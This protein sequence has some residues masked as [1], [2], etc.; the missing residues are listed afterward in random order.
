MHKSF[1][2]VLLAAFGWGAATVP[3]VAHAVPDNCY[4]IGGPVFECHHGNKVVRMYMNFKMWENGKYDIYTWDRSV[5]TFVTNNEEGKR[6]Y[7]N[8][9]TVMSL[10]CGEDKSGWTICRR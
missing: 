3:G 10:N 1:L 5:E 6:R 7:L 8:I 4:S 2:M 9:E